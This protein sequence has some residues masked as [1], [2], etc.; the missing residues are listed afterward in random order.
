MSNKAR[1]MNFA[2]EDG[3]KKREVSNELMKMEV[4]T[5]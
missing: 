2:L 4:M 3:I 1:E 5:W